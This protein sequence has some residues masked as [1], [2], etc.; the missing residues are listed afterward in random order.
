MGAIRK[1]PMSR[2]VLEPMI[3]AWN[4][5]KLAGM[6]TPTS[7]GRRRRCHTSLMPSLR[8]NRRMSR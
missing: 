8:R 7:T 6:R 1:Q 3:S 2:W 4:T 5:T